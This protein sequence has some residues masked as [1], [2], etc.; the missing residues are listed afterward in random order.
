MGVNQALAMTRLSIKLG[1]SPR[2]SVVWYGS[3]NYLEELGR[4]APNALDLLHLIQQP[5]GYRRDQ[6]P[7]TEAQ[8]LGQQ[9]VA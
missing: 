1:M 3:G 7:R 2:G 8:H 4:L 5:T 9:P 6:L